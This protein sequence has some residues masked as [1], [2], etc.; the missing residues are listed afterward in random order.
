MK[1]A[2]AFITFPGSVRCW[3]PHWSRVSPTAGPSDRDVTSRLGFRSFRSSTREAFDAANDAKRV[4]GDGNGVLSR[5]DGAP[6]AGSQLPYRF[7]DR[8]KHMVLADGFD[9]ARTAGLALSLLIRQSGNSDGDAIRPEISNCL[10][11]RS[12]TRCSRCR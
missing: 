8:H 11:Q 7:F 1:R 10:L 6:G 4:S 5:S 2:S 9:Q 12:A 3:R